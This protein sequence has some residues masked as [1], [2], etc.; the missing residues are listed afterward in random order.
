MTIFIL[1]FIWLL[2]AIWVHAFYAISLASS[3]RL[4]LLAAVSSRRPCAVDKLSLFGLTTFDSHLWRLLTFRNPWNIY[5][6][7]LADEIARVR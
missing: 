2:P 5:P 1:A 4:G 6:L 7:G 3:Q